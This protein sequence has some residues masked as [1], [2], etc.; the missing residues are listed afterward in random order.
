[1]EITVV[2]CTYNRCESLKKALGSIATQEMPLSTDWEVLVVDNNSSDQTRAVVEDFCA[3][4]PGHFRYLFEPQ[5]GKSNALNSGVRSA[6]GDVLAF[7]DDD[8]IVQAGWLRNLT[9]PLLDKKCVGVGGRVFP[10]W[11]VPPPV[12]LQFAEP[13]VLAALA[14]FDLGVESGP[15]SQPPFGNNMAFQRAIFRKHG[16]FRVDLGPRPG[17]EIRSED[18]DF[19]RRLLE[20]G[21]QLWYEPSAVV[22]HSVPASRMRKR[23][24]LNWWFDKSRADIREF[25]IRSGG[26]WC[27]AGVP[28]FL[29][30]RLAV[31]TIRWMLTINSSQRFSCKVKAWGRVGEILECYRQSRA[32]LHSTP[33]IPSV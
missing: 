26:R 16:G 30:R 22:F 12:W 8:V 33:A 6:R 13:W 4:F 27:V 10:E 24:F 11:N 7:T 28:L 3:R 21:E 1:M 15:L 29:F 2:L 32:R 18:T 19:G 17:S 25:G 5:P 31:W 23:Y 9:S 20:G 14:M